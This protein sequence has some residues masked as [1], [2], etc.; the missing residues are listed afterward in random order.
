MVTM[1]PVTEM[2]A[3]ASER[4][5]VRPDDGKSTSIFEKVSID[6]QR[7][8]LKQLSPATDWIMRVTGDRV[9]RPYRIWQAGIMDRVPPCIDHAVVAMEIVGAGDDAMLSI[10]MRDVGSHLVPEGDGAVTF[11][12]HAGFISHLAELSAKFWGFED[13]VGD[14]ATMEERLRFFDA[15]N[16]SRELAVMDPPGVIVAADDGWR[17]LSQRSAFMSEVAELV[18]R[19][20]GTLTEPLS[21]TPYTFLH[22]DWKM[23][24]LG[25]H[26]DGRTIL[27]DWAYPGSG[28]ACWDLCWYVALNRARLPES[29]EATIERF[30]ADLERHGVGTADWFERQMDL[31]TIAIMVTFG[32]E[33][34]LGDESELRWWELRVARAIQRQAVDL[35]QLTT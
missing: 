9:H 15:T 31:S 12:Q 14:L 13:T 26:P 23:G 30:R 34:A 17:R 20:P 5:T 21:G 28:P 2:L 35:P 25:S 10:L 32:W 3:R 18:W 33:K 29:K 27:L 19:D 11:E 22:G 24:N 6:G 16:V 4:E 8:F 1:Q 7:Y